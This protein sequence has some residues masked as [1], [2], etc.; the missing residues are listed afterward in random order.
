MLISFV[1]DVY[2]CKHLNKLIW[3]PIKSLMVHEIALLRPSPEVSGI[4]QD[5]PPPSPLKNQGK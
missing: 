5:Q 3:L 2:V 1:L 4:H